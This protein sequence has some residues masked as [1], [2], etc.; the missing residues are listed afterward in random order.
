M[1]TPRPGAVVALAVFALAGVL[2]AAVSTA[3]FV[4]FLDRQVHAVTC[5]F[6]PGIGA[7]DT[8][9]TSGC[10]AVLMSPYSAVLR[11][12]TWGGIP[13]SLGALAVFAFLLFR[14]ADLLVTRRTGDRQATA[15]L[16]AA[17]ALPV[18]TSIAYF[19]IA[20]LKVGS[21]C[22]LCVGIY[23]ASLGAFASALVAYRNAPREAGAQPPAWGGHALA[24]LEGV[25]FVALPVLLYLGLKPAYSDT[26]GRCGDLIRPE[27]RYGVRV[28]LTDPP[29]G[30][31]A[32]EVLDPLCPACKAFSERLAVSGLG[33]RLR[34][35]L[36]LFPLDK[37]CNWMVS[38]S[39]HPGACAVSE[40]VLCGGVKARAVLE[41]ALANQEELRE[42]GK[43]TGRLTNRIRQQFPELGDC[44]GK[45]AVRAKLNR[46]LRWAVANSLP[47]Q[48][49]QLFVRDRKVC[50]EDT[51][52]GLEFV[53]ARMLSAPDAGGRTGR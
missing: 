45:P 37:E 52:L 18:V 17:S 12:W 3:D 33:E 29:G 9:G 46:S 48:T 26:I 36:V 43:D 23:V 10:H 22:K 40:A 50:E 5:S 44:L 30:V 41:W 7:R 25:V 6:V 35:E 15:F 14:A 21:V 20:V 53:L 4:A 1:N 34:R 38:E 2:F 8:A 19:L 11:T 47:V 32:V 42:L 24:F 27:D 31:P 49:P 39:L 28:R 51:D 16:V 13:I